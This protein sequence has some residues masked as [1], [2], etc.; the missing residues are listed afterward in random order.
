MIRACTECG[1]EFQARGDWQRL[2]WSCWQERK[3]SRAYDLGYSEGYA[4]GA[5]ERGKAWGR[6]LALERGLLRDLVAL[7]HPDRHP[8]ERAALATRV[9]AALLEARGREA[10]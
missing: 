3:L 10:A 7:C 8:P 5:G 6:S 2:C 4:A 9:T 1:D